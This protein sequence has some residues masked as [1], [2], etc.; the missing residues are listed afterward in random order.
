MNSN[1]IISALEDV[2]TAFKSK[3][4]TVESKLLDRVQSLEVRLDNSIRDLSQSNEGYA[5]APGVKRA[6]SMGDQAV[7]AFEENFE[8]FKKS[9]RVN[10]ELQTKAAGDPVT[11]ASGRS[12]MS[13]GAGSPGLNTFGLQNAL[14]SRESIGTSAVEYSR[15][16]G[17]EGGAALQ[18]TEG[19]DKSAVRPTHSLISQSSLTVAAYSV[20]STQAISDAAELRRSVE[21]TLSRSIS[22]T[23]DE[24]LWD[25]SVTPSWAGFSTLAETNA[26][27][28]TLLAD[29]VSDTVA[30]MQEAGFMPDRVVVSPSTWVEIVTE[31]SDSG[32]GPYLS[33]S[34]LTMPGNELRGLPVVLSPSVPAGQALVI[35]TAHV[36]LLTVANPVLQI[37]TINDQFTKNLATLLMETRFIPIFRTVGAMVLTAPD[38]VTI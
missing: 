3:L 1:E 8:I 14:V 13:G 37:G 35:D 36:E 19:S 30:Q 17:L 16:T 15:Y 4:G 2:G 5:T 33:S 34:Y 27:T 38:G 31:R 23:M 11:T 21:I 24:L 25:G 12:I 22:K 29:A 28:F 18:A 26:S 32:T 20:M 9:G 6:D 7:R 10:L